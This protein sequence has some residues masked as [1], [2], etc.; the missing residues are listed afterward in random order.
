M[1]GVAGVC[2]GQVTTAGKQMTLE[3]RAPA[4]TVDRE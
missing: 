3:L 1:F 2:S 4:V